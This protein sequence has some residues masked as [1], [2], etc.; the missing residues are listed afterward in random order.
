VTLQLLHDGEE[1]LDG[2]LA[3]QLSSAS[4]RSPPVVVT[5]LV[6]PSLYVPSP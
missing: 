1:Q 4:A 2:A 3:L 5:V 6:P